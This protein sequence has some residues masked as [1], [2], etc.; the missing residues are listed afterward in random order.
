MK[1]HPAGKGHKGIET[2]P[3]AEIIK[4]A[5]F[6]KEKLREMT[7]GGEN[8]DI[9]TFAPTIQLKLFSC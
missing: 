9:R 4:F 3:E 6:T 5:H 7:A 1:I 8:L 2:P